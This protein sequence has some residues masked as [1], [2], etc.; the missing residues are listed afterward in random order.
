[1]LSVFLHA[2]NYIL[3]LITEMPDVISMAPNRKFRTHTTRSWDFLGLNYDSKDNTLLQQGNYGEDII[4]GVIDSGYISI[5]CNALNACI[6]NSYYN[7]A[8][9]TIFIFL[10]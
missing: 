2:F 10:V 3:Q 5:S 8:V 7:D 4:I 9:L 1:L 6:C